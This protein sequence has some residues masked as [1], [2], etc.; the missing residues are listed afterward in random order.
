M[1]TLQ[2][3]AL[4]FIGR[5][6]PERVKIRATAKSIPLPRP[7]VQGGMP[8]MEAL[9]KR[10]SIRE[11]SPDPLPPR[12]LSDVLWAAFGVNRAAANGRTAP[13]A[14]DA[15]EIDIYAAM[16][17]GL[18]VYDPFAH[19][20]SLV[21]AVDA[22]KVTGYQ[23]FVG[24]APLD[25]VYVADHWHLSAAPAEERFAYSAVAAGAIAENVYLYCASAGLATVVRGWLDCAALA[26]ALR[27]SEHEHVVIA[28]TVGYPRM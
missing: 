4:S 23:D 7:N 13:S 25:L 26:Q 9:A 10:R 1:S 21:A 27:L 14:R 20:L 24:E 15:Q 3:V 5:L 8:L 17:G 22:R 18:Y 28:Q 12:V 11:F 2:K 6:K 16:A 19:N